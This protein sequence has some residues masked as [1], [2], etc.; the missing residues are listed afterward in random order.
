MYAEAGRTAGSTTSLCVLR[1]D[2]E[3]QC[4]ALVVG[5]IPGLPPTAFGWRNASA[6]QVPDVLFCSSLPCVSAGG[7]FKQVRLQQFMS[8][9]V[10]TGHA[11]T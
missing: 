3:I 2:L 6:V 5:S 1:V 10:S 9:L 7:P 4:T 8:T 11:A